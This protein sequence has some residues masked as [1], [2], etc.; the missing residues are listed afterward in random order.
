[1]SAAAAAARG[2]HMTSAEYIDWKLEK[3]AERDD[4]FSLTRSLEGRQIERGK[5]TAGY[6][7][8]DESSTRKR[9]GDA[10]DTGLFIRQLFLSLAAHTLQMFKRK[11]MMKTR[12]SKI[13]AL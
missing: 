7:E 4:S 9:N 8:I 5:N 6:M 12:T 13:C 2:L 11:R 10:R 3:F 1:M